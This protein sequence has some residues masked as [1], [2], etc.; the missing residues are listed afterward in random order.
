[1]FSQDVVIT[2]GGYVAWRYRGMNDF[3]YVPIG[4]LQEVFEIVGIGEA[5]ASIMV[6]Y[7][8]WLQ[9]KPLPMH[10]HGRFEMQLVL[11]GSF[12]YIVETEAYQLDTGD[13]CLTQP[14]EIH[15]ISPFIGD[16]CEIVDIQPESFKHNEI[17][18]TLLGT[19]VK[20][21]RGC[22]EIIPVINTIID[23]LRHPKNLSQMY[24]S[25]LITQTLVCLCRHILNSEEHKTSPDYAKDNLLVS[26]LLYIESHAHHGMTVEEIA[27]AVGASTSLLSHR[28][29]Q[30]LGVS[31]CYYNRHLVMM[32]ARKLIDKDDML[33]K[34]I[35]DIMG[36][37]SV[38]FFSSTFKTSFGI[39][40]SEYRRNQRSR[41]S[42]SQN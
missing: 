18:D 8:K 26:A 35:A 1:M 17:Y 30:V 39:S 27:R 12:K 13:I 20:V 29:S 32:R 41:S 14:G 6:R 33:L 10:M 21:L 4:D 31:P 9:N 2:Y 16:N 15:S 28:F 37:P 40:P 25:S 5:P 7:I 22:N 19:K 3:H 34:E 36:F 38:N 42:L 24:E 11:N 23:E